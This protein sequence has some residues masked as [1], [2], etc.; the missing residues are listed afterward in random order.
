ME[1]ANYLPGLVTAKI[2]HS[3]ANKLN[4]VEKYSRQHG[5]PT[6]PTLRL[7][8]NEGGRVIALV[9]TGNVNLKLALRRNAA[10]TG[11]EEWILLGDALK[12]SD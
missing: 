4:Q 6:Q 1:D 2:L 7:L 12:V 5:N 11:E 10:T 9:Q 3:L 8:Q